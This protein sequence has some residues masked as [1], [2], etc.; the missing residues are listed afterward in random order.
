[1]N[2]LISLNEIH[3]KDLFATALSSRNSDDIILELRRSV[4]RAICEKFKEA[5]LLILNSADDEVS[6]NLLGHRFESCTPIESLHNKILDVNFCAG[7]G[8]SNWSHKAINY[9]HGLYNNVPSINTFNECPN[10]SIGNILFLTENIDADV[11][12]TPSEEIKIVGYSY[13][14]S[15]KKKKSFIAILGIHFSEIVLKEIIQE[16]LTND[17]INNLVEVRLG[18]T[19]YPVIFASKYTGV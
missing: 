5:G 16:H 15:K 10:Y 11:T 12:I 3:I 18:Y 7:Y 13:Q 19:K 8:T 2:Y 4:K 1:M 6:A 17:S 9:L 14:V